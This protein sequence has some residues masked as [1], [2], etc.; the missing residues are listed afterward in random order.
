MRLRFHP[1]VAAFTRTDLASSVAALGLVLVLALNF[2][3]TTRQRSSATRCLANF[4]AQATGW[5]G[6]AL[7]NPSLLGMIQGGE[8]TLAEPGPRM[9]Q[10]FWALGW[11]DWGTAAD[12]T[13]RA[14]LR[15]E[16]FAAHLP[17]GL[18][19]PS[20]YAVFRCPEDRFWSR[21]QV[22]RGWPTTGSGRVRSYSQNAA[23]GPGNGT[24][25]PLVA[26]YK[27]VT[28]LSEIAKP[29][30]TFIMIEEHPDSI[31]D[32]G[33][34]PPDAL[35]WIDMP[36]AFHSRGAHFACADGHAGSHRWRSAKLAVPVRFNFSPLSHNATDPDYLWLRERTPGGQ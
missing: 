34:Y 14:R 11:L 16:A 6:Y 20:D 26:P 10:D 32:P 23:V 17:G 36:A 22:A 1:T 27:S 5:A 3:G 19:T 35:Q 2:A 8:A 30:E 9:P 28:K 13:N 21:Q 29:A 15:N 7:G 25:G 18:R 4:K 12:N 33:F 31:N 24:L